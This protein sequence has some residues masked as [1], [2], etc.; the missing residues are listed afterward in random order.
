LIAGTLRLGQLLIP[1]S[2]EYQAQTAGGKILTL[3][4]NLFLTKSLTG[5]QLG[6]VL[7][8]VTERRQRRRPCVCASNSFPASPKTCRA[9]C[10]AFTVVRKPA[11]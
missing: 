5:F 2:G 3:Q 7:V 4:R 10:I 6:V 8:D 11:K 1:A 9:C